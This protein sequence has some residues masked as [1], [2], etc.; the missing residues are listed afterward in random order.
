MKAFQR[1]QIV[2]INSPA[3]AGP[4]ECEWAERHCQAA[5]RAGIG[6]I[7]VN[8]P[9]LPL[10]PVLVANPTKVYHWFS[11]YAASW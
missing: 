8:Y 7:Q 3:L 11:N 6:E 9:Y 2:P 5:L 4:N 1:V 10:H